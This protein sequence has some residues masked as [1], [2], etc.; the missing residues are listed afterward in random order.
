MRKLL[1]LSVIGCALS[2]AT[3]ITFA[4]QQY[5]HTDSTPYFLVNRG[6]LV[7][8]R[9]FDWNAACAAAAIDVQPHYSNGRGAI[10]PIWAFGCYYTMLPPLGDGVTEW[11]LQNWVIP[12]LWVPRRIEL[13]SE[14]ESMP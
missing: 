11:F 6:P 4:Q 7:G 14:H 1:L 13:R 2:A 5:H 10:H 8:Q 12:L 3:S 9:H